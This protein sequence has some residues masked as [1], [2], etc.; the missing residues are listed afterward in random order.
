[1][2]LSYKNARR[3]DA[4][5]KAC[6]RLSAFLHGLLHRQ[7]PV[8]PA[9]RAASYDADVYEARALWTQNRA[10]QARAI[11]ERLEKKFKGRMPIGGLYWLKSRMAAERGDFT[12]VTR[13]LDLALKEPSTDS[14]MHDKILW[15]SAWSE[16]RQNHL[17][18]ATELFTH[19]SEQSDD[20][21]TRTRA[22]FWLGK[23]LS[24]AKKEEQAKPVFEQVIAADPLGYYGLLA[25]RHL[26]LEITFKPVNDPTGEEEAAP[27]PLDTETAEWLYLVGENDA[28]TALLD[29]AWASYKKQHDQ[30]DQG[31]FALLKYYAKAG[32]YVKLYSSL[33]V[34]PP[35]R[36]KSVLQRHPELLFPQP[37]STDVRTASLEFGVQPE[38]IYS[39]MRQESAF[40]PRARSFADA[41]GLLQILPEVAEPLSSEFKIPYSDMEDLYTPAVNIRIGAAHLR[42]LLDRHKGR[43]ILAVASYNANENAIRSWMKNRYRG[44]SLEFI[45]EIPYE[46]TRTYVRLVMRNLIF[47][48]LLNSKS[49]AIEFPSWVLK[50]DAS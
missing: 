31:W 47:Y 16:R 26:G 37:W 3:I 11:F 42:E 39:I 44:D 50:L 14:A 25:H 15:S 41:F 48:S 46:E 34:L 21:S 10:S 40:D 43:F 1:L 36:R 38:L 4:H 30:N 9:L 7:K 27:I 23:T 33:N 6:R 20:D 49:A 13:N 5:L 45:E 17:D 28:L 24:D 35:D 19:L 8:N 18:R 12:A 2:R 29:R 32:L 22:L